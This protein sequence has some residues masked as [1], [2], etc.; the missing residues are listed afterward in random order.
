MN[1]RDVVFVDGETSSQVEEFLR[2]IAE[3]KSVENVDSYVANL[4][5]AKVADILNE[6]KEV[7]ARSPEK[8]VEAVYNQL[9]AIVLTQSTDSSSDDSVAEIVKDLEANVEN[10][11]VGLKVLNN[12][13]NLLPSTDIR[14]Q[15]FEAIVRVA[16]K[17]SLLAT[18]LP[19]IS[20]LP[21]MFEE[22]S[23]EEQTKAQVLLLVRDSLDKAQFTSEAYETELVFLQSISAE[24]SQTKEVATSAIVHFVNLTAVCDL[25]ALASQPAVQT[26]NKEQKLGDAGVLLE[27]LLSSDYKAWKQFAQDKAAVLAS[28]GVDAEKASDKVRLLTVASLA[29]ESLGQ[30]VPF[31][32]VAQAI[33]V[34]ED[35]V[36]V[37]IIDVI[38]AGLI[39]GKMNQ[40]TRTVLPTRSTYRTFGEDQWK[41]LASRL[42]MW[43]ESLEKLQPVIANAKLVAQQQ[44]M[45]MAGQ[46]RV[47]IKE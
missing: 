2:Y 36:E 42:D 31:A 13:Y 40:V 21:K 3:L 27:A 28:L 38:R 34:D 33:E 12:L 18:I 5:D 32:A 6:S 8:K 17:T 1:A 47:T 25:D 37:W 4:K 35:E 30:D 20:R 29:A 23:V 14:R 39:Q 24:A 41:L 15:V 22:W 43:K 26:L 10:G 45:Q 9:F 19:L 44:A 7:L 11:A 16:A 46:A